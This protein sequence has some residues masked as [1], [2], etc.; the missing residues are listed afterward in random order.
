MTI[1]RSDLLRR[2]LG[3]L[4]DHPHDDTVGRITT[5]LDVIS[6]DAIEAALD[7]LESDGLVMHAGEHWS[8]TGSGWSAARADEPFPGLD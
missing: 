8:L 4:R 3:C 5:L 2:V 6:T 1:P 7:A